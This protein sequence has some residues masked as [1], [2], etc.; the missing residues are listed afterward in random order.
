M[1]KIEVACQMFDRETGAEGKTAWPIDI[2]EEQLTEVM[3]IPGG[4]FTPNTRKT[5]QLD[6]VS[7]WSIRLLPLLITMLKS[8]QKRKPWVCWLLA[9]FETDPKCKHDWEIRMIWTEDLQQVTN[10]AAEQTLVLT[11]VVEPPT[12]EL[13]EIV[14]KTDCVLLPGTMLD[15]EA[16][17]QNR[18]DHAIVQR[19]FRR[20]HAEPI[21]EEKTTPVRS[22]FSLDFDEE[23]VE[24]ALSNLG[25][26]DILW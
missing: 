2:T 3:A 26:E 13:T 21:S 24:I 5:D 18:R 15:K 12:I 4:I 23:E 22:P 14:S 16:I 17:R 1:L 20:I 8:Y 25:K 6:G 9:C 11:D 10:D 19:M 7:I